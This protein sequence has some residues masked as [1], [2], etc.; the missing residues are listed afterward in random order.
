MEEVKKF[1]SLPEGETQ[2]IIGKR[3]AFSGDFYAEGLLR[4]DG[5]FRG[6]VK[7]N[8][9]VLLGE[10]GKFEGEIYAKY[11]RVGG[12]IKGNVYGYEKIDILSTGKIIGDLYS[13]KIYAEDGMKVSG[14][15]NTVK[16]ED[17]KE[18]FDR[19]VKINKN[20]FS[21]DF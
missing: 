13:Q 17:M 7:S 3:N 16:E 19:N 6:S 15:I 11:V 8:D 9:V 4:I 10:G 12:K 5:N 2:S 20:V 18:I 1:D 14:R 21:E